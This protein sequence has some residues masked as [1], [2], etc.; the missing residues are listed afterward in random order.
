MRE[1]LDRRLGPQH[2]NNLMFAFIGSGVSSAV[3]L[4]VF[5][6]A[7]FALLAL[8]CAARR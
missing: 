7:V 5:V 2:W 6:A 4:D 3:R 8:Y 1:W